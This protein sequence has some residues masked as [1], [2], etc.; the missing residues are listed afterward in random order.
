MRPVCSLGI[1]GETGHI[2]KAIKAGVLQSEQPGVMASRVQ[3]V[4]GSPWEH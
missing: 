4:R 2:E 3:G 1:R